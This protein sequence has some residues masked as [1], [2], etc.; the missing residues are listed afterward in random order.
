MKVNLANKH[1]EFAAENKCLLREGSYNRVNSLDI[2]VS[3]RRSV[4]Y[5]MYVLL[6][7]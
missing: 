6:L 4:P 2:V 1:M 3:R 5:N 7:N